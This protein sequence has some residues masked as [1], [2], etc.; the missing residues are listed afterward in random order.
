MK[1]LILPLSFVFVFLFGLSVTAIGQVFTNHYQIVLLDSDEDEEKKK[2]KDGDEESSANEEYD[3]DDM[4]IDEGHD[5]EV[6]SPEAQMHSGD[7]TQD[8]FDAE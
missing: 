3:N 6:F 7:C 4:L 2:K 5:N 8:G 1:K